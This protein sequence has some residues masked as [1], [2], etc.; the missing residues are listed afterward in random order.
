MRHAVSDLLL[1]LGVVGAGVWHN[2]RAAAMIVGDLKVIVDCWWRATKLASTAQLYNISADPGERHDLAPSQPQ[3]LPP[4]LARLDYW[5]G[6]SV[7]PYS[8]TM[9]E[10]GCGDGKPLGTDPPH[11]DSWC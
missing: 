7:P 2:M 11:W 1:P 10:E 8:E 5:E 3:L 9:D 4:L 6:V